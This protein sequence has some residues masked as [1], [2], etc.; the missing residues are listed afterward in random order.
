MND[1]K[2]TET[3]EEISLQLSRYSPKIVDTYCGAIHALNQNEYSDR[4]V[5]FAHSLREVIDLLS[6]SGQTEYEL[7]KS[8]DKKIRK[9]LLQ[10]VIDPLG[11]QSYSFSDKYD[12]LMKNMILSVLLHI[13]KKT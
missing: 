1:F 7:N 3:Q 8:L 12:A 11:K 13:T 2:L 10:S 4:L 9:H 6:R 5:H